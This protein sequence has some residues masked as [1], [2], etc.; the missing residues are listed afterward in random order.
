MPLIDGEPALRRVCE[1]IEQAKRSVW[2][3]ITFMWA[4]CQMPDGRGTPSMFS[5]ELLQVEWMSEL[6][7][8]VPMPRRNH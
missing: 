4:S 2:V 7:F 8:G 5:I 1:A 3:T 6:S